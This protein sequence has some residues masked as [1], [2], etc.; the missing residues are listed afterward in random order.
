MEFLTNK[1]FLLAATLVI[2]LLSQL[3]QKRLRYAFLNPLLITT[4]LLIGM[5][6]V[7][8]IPYES[9]AEG[10]KYIDFWLKPAIVA[11]GVPLYKQLETIKKQLVPIVLAELAGCVIGIVSVV[12]IAKLLGATQEVV[13]SLVPKSVTTPIAM[14]V[15]SAIGGIPS[16][17]AAVVVCTGIFGGM[18]GFQ[19][20]SLSRVK[21]PI[22][23]GLSMGTAAHAVGTSAA[24]TRGYRYGAFS[25]L[26]LTLNGLFTAIL[27]PLILR[28]LGIIL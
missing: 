10:G 12:V 2:Y 15:S 3:L 13:L 9:Y 28:L 5:L 16:L 20:M 8:D 17:T 22:S 24:M 7:F 14:E 6:M 1:Y 19:M 11:L 26:G 27:T 4:L 21:R 23:Q 25:S 18:A